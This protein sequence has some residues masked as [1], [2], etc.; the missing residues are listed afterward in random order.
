MSGGVWCLC[1]GDVVA[2][3]VGADKA[4]ERVWLGRACLCQA[5][6][7]RVK[8]LIHMYD[9]SLQGCAPLASLPHSTKLWLQAGSNT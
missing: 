1:C 7:L 5:L 6:S 3:R 9:M 4:L 2:G 8:L